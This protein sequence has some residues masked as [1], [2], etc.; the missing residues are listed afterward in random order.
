[1]VRITRTATVLAVGFLSLGIGAT[2]VVAE[3]KI[4]VIFFA[5]HN[6]GNATLQVTSKEEDWGVHGGDKSVGP[7]S[8]GQ[9]R[10]EL[11]QTAFVVDY[12]RQFLC[13]WEVTVNEYGRKSTW[14]LQ[15]TGGK[16]GGG[17]PHPFDKDKKIVTSATCNHSDGWK[18]AIGRTEGGSSPGFDNGCF[19]HFR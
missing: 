16:P 2:G 9:Y 1:M 17:A 14:H 10:C 6:P 12:K 7:K 5:I 3:D 19:G 13:G 4:P 15:V 18:I 11:K 8:V